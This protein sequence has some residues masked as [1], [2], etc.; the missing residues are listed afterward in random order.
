MISYPSLNFALGDN[1]DMLRD[2]VQQF[3]A[4][5]LAPRAAG[6]D[7][8]VALDDAAAIEAALAAFVDRIEDGSAVRIGRPQAERHG[9]RART[10][11]LAALLDALVASR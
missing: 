2:S 7:S 4:K 6:I 8:I 9:R 10:G 3:V 1:I 5:E 11:E